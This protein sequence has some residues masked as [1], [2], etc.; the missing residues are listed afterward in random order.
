VRVHGDHKVQ[1]GL[2]LLPF[3]FES[4][5]SAGSLLGL[6][7]NVEAIKLTNALVWR[8]LGVQAS[9]NFGKFASYKVGVFDGYDAAE[10]NVEADQRFT[11]HV[12]VNVVGEVETGWFAN[13]VRLDQPTYVSLGAGFDTQG[14]ATI[15]DGNVRD[16]EAWVVDLQSAV[17]IEGIGSL[18]V[19]AAYY[20]WDNLNFKGNTSFVEAGFLAHNAMVTAKWALQAPDQGEDVADYTVGLHYLL[21]GNALRGGVEYRTGDS[22]DAVLAQVQFLL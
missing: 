21:K 22:P 16:A 12:A 1:A 8:D 17:K 13:Q 2:I 7:Y 19:D 9:G 4:L 11:G 18:L 14:K 5:S 20:D 15:K 3:S 6:D 10:K